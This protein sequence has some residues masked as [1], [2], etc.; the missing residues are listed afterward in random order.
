MDM[1]FVCLCMHYIHVVFIFFNIVVLFLG[2]FF[3]FFKQKTAYEMRIS[4]WSSDVCSSDLS[5]SC[6][7]AWD[8]LICLRTTWL[9][10]QA[11]SNTRS[12]RRRSRYLSIS[13]AQSSRAAPT[14]LTMSMVAVWSG[15]SVLRVRLATIGS[16]TEPLLPDRAS[17][18]VRA[19]GARPSHPRPLTRW[20]S[21]S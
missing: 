5:Y 14:P 13:A 9:C 15:A 19:H 6:A 17:V 18:P 16:S 3:F 2:F 12:A 21:V 1:S 11:R 20:R 7:S 8:A 4:D 10:V